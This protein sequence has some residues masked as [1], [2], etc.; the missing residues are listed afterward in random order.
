M[1]QIVTKFISANAIT[2]AKLA[3]SPAHSYKGNNTGSTANAADITSTQLTADLNLFSSSLQGLV[4]ASGGGTTNFLRADGTFAAPSAGI[5]TIGT[6]D[7]QTKSANGAVIS[8]SSLVLQS[9]D[10]SNPGLVT[11]GAQSFAG[12]KTFSGNILSS[13]NGTLDIGS[14]GN[15]FNN[16]YGV[17]LRVTSGKVD[18]NGVGEWDQSFAASDGVTYDS[19][20]VATSAKSIGM[21]TPNAAN[22]LAKPVGFFTGNSTSSGNSGSITFKTGTSTAT[23][24]DI[25]LDSNSISLNPV[26]S[27]NMNS[28]KIVSL[29]DPTAAQ[30]AAT[31]NYVDTH[32]GTG[33]VTSVALAAPAIFSVSGSPVTTSGT[34]TLSYSGTALPIANGGTN[35][36]TALNNNR[37]MQSSG[38]AIVEAAAITANRAL[39]SNASGI[40]V[41]SATTDTE[42]GFVS[43]VTSAI[44]TQ[45]NNR[46]QLSGG[47]MSGAIAMGTNKITGMGDPTAA[48]DAA[49]KNYVDNLITGIS[50]KNSAR[51]IATSNITLSGTQTIDG[52]AVIAGDRVLAQ[53]QTTAAN[54]GIYVVAAGAWSRSTDADSGSE[55]INAA[56]FISE[57][58]VNANTAWVQT[59]P[60]PITIGTTAI[61][62]VKFSSGV[63]VSFGNGLQT[64]SNVVS[65]K[66]ADASIAVAAGG[67]SVAYDA[68]GALTTSGSGAKVRVDAVT[69]KINGSNNLESLKDNSENLTLNGTDITNQYKDLS[70]AIYGTSASVNSAVLAVV[71]G[72]IQQ[73]TVDYTVSLTGGSGGVTRI[74]FAGDL[75]TG[76]NAALV[77]GDILMVSYSYLT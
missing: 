69:T 71:G 53:A 15:S 27:V 72:P 58:T 20:L 12:A 17:N 23:R 22:T 4:P 40:P 41:A 9:A 76:G 10:A 34:L 55:L 37:L 47:T 42:L 16:I 67:V 21:G 56:V 1:S 8:G 65:V 38:G 31:K 45:L 24:G 44:Q 3:Q 32:A 13:S 28:K 66:S 54:C 2:N 61:T 5:T 6:I 74:T 7:S 49:T 51:A 75:A 73:K 29:L 77:N 57:G 25:T 36:T 35:S 52:V 70:F 18:V 60:A 43:G 68:A 48:Q 63:A 33:T 50:W 11:T 26:T 30:D 14:S 39:A 62:F 64:I 59:A 46:L 19:A